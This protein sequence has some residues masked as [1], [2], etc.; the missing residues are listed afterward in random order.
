MFSSAEQIVANHGYEYFAICWIEISP[1]LNIPREKLGNVSIR[2]FGVE[3]IRNSDCDFA[4]IGNKLGFIEANNA[5]QIGA[6]T[7]DVT[8][9]SARLDYVLQLLAEQLWRIIEDA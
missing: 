1:L 2:I 6:D 8:I 4:G 3:A 7:A 5:Q 9:R